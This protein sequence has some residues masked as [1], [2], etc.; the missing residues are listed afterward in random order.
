MKEGRRGMMYIRIVYTNGSYDPSI[1][2]R[3]RESQLVSFLV[4]IC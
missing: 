2:E 3:E 4:M 1:R